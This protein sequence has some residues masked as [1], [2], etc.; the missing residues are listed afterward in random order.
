MELKVQNL[1]KKYG[2]KEVLK[3]IDIT[4]ESSEV[5]A[6]IGRNGSGKTTFLKIL[7]GMIEKNSGEIFLDG[8]NIYNNPELLKEI[9]YIPDNFNYFKYDRIVKVLEYYKLIYFKFDENY[10]LKQLKNNGIDAKKRFSQLSKGETKLVSTILGL[11]C[12]TKFVFLDEPLDGVDIININK[13]LT[14]ILEAQEIG[15]GVIVSSHQLEHLYKIS[16]KVYYLE[17]DVELDNSYEI[18]LDDYKK[19]QLVYEDKIPN[20]L[21]ELDNLKVINNV[22]RVY[23][24][25]VYDIENNFEEKLINSSP[26]Q[27][28]LLGVTL[29]DIFIFKNREDN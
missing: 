6:L 2:K 17:K 7:V 15:K 29:E 12:N 28:D 25:V 19:F 27:Y 4:L 21:L 24:V 1:N 8:I 20:S 11:A 13:I 5:L 23:T 10:F 26:I 3:N 16:N 18:L 14:Y 9:I 22:G